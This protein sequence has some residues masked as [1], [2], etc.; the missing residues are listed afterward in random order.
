M[1]DGELKDGFRGFQILKMIPNPIVKW[2]WA[3]STFM[4]F[5]TYFLAKL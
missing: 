5:R 2:P 4:F 1:K 3:I